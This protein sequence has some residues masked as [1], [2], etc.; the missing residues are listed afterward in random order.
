MNHKAL[1]LIHLK[2]GN[3]NQFYLTMLVSP[4]GTGSTTPSSNGWYS[5]AQKVTLGLN[6][7]EKQMDTFLLQRPWAIN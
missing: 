2:L 4:S 3:Q 5:A 7:L 1:A 6:R